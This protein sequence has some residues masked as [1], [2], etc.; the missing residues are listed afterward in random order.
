MKDYLAEIKNERDRQINAEGWSKNHDDSHIN[1]ELAL[2]AACYAS[3][4][5]IYIAQYSK[6]SNMTRFN[7]AWPWDT[8]WDKRD[9]HSRER[10]LIIAAALIIAE[11]ERLDRLNNN[12]NNL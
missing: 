3:S 8:E 2:A 10:Q 4:K 9:K 1:G 11:L 6:M 12:N 5:P 7:E